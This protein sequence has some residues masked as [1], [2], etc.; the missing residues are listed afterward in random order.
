MKKKFESMFVVHVR[1]DVNTEHHGDA[2]D[3]H[4]YIQ[5]KFLEFLKTS[6]PQDQSYPTNVFVNTTAEVENS[7]RQFGLKARISY[8]STVDSVMSDASE[9]RRSPNVWFLGRLSSAAHMAR[10]WVSYARTISNNDELASRARSFDT[11]EAGG[12]SIQLPTLPWNTM[13]LIFNRARENYYSNNNK[14]WHKSIKETT[15]DVLEGLFEDGLPVD[16][17]LTQSEIG[18]YAEPF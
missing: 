17:E 15:V 11:Q 2:S 4:V 6:L 13:R 8:A 12:D 14:M 5:N 18:N 10:E 7:D 3:V 9:S 16:R 1:Y